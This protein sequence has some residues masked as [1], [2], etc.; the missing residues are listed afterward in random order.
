MIHIFDA[1]HLVLLVEIYSPFLVH[2][3]LAYLFFSG[4]II[5]NMKEI[6]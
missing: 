1:S 5:L 4:L 3:L 2:Y 6:I